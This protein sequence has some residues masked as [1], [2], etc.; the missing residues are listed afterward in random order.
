MAN[1]II[2][3]CKMTYEE[4]IDEMKRRGKEA[5][6]KGASKHSFTYIPSEKYPEIVIKYPGHTPM[7]EE[8]GNSP[9]QG[10]YVMKMKSFDSDDEITLKHFEMCDLLFRASKGNYEAYYKFL[11]DVCLHGTNIDLSKYETIIG[12]EKLALT[13][14]WL[15][16]Q[17]DINHSRDNQHEG[18]YLTFCRY[19]E[20]V[21]AAEY[22]PKIMDEMEKR[23]SDSR[24]INLDV[25]KVPHPCYYQPMVSF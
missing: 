24:T 5:I 18:H 7:Q 12:A 1:N 16:V 6:E 17:E 15:T 8:Y 4:A 19:Y 11:E 20:A 9:K 23:C 2:K 21:Y 22:D 13:L 10:D 14:F 25:R 3:D